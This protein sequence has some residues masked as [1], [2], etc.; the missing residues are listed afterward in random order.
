MIRR[1]NRVAVDSGLLITSMMDMF[2]IILLFLLNFFDP[3]AGSATD[4]FL[5]ATS[6]QAGV[7]AGV[8]LDVSPT[9]VSVGGMQVL[10]LDAGRLPSDAARQGRRIDVVYDA[11]ARAK[12]GA[13]DADAPLIVRADR[14][15]AFGVLGDIL[16]SA[17]AAGWAR[18][19]FVVVDEAG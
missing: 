1:R 2:T 17:G 8:T 19:R 16:Y 4:L 18:Y 7:E 10:A 12:N 11:L 5:P 13:T 9:G 15:T 3:A 14:R 6:A